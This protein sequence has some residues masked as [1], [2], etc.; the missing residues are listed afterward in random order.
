M[1]SDLNQ[2][3]FLGGLLEGLKFTI[4]KVTPSVPD[5]TGWGATFAHPT[6]GSK[7]SNAN[8]CPHS[9]SLRD[10]RCLAQLFD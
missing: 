6:A 10:L 3:L 5:R 8:V 4:V 7:S 2:Q 1:P 9:R